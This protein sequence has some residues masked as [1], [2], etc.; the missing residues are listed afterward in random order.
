MAQAQLFRHLGKAALFPS[1]GENLGDVDH[2]VRQ[3]RFEVR[4]EDA[5]IPSHDRL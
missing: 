3:V 1:C 2:P 5:S 4:E